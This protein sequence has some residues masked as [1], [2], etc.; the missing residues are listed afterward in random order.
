MANG[1]IKEQVAVVVDQ[2]GK[3]QAQFRS[4]WA[5]NEAKAFLKSCEKVDY[6]KGAQVVTGD[7]AKKAL[8]SGKI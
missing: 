2:D 8:E 1:E 5:E 3:V 6:L 4:P 7:R